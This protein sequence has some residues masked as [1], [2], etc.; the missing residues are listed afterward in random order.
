MGPGMNQQTGVNQGHKDLDEP[1]HQVSISVVLSYFAL[2]SRDGGVAEIND[3]ICLLRDELASE[4]RRTMTAR[5][6]PRRIGSECC[7]LSQPTVFM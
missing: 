4:R 7:A 5:P 2:A 6:P 1:R 3:E